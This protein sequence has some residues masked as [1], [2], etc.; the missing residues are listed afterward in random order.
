MVQSMKQ[1]S[2]S[3]SQL[4]ACS[5]NARIGHGLLLV[6]DSCLLEW[7]SVNSFYKER[8]ALTAAYWNALMNAQDVFVTEQS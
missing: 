2:V 5:G 4:L 8:W 3:A 7:F 1:S 6:T